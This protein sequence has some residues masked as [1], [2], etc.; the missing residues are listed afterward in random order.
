[1]DLGGNSHGEL[2][3]GGISSY[4]TSPTQV[5][6]ATNWEK[7]SAG[8]SHSLGLRQD[9]TLWAWGADFG[10]QIG[11][12]GISDLS[13]IQISPKQ[14]GNATD[15]VSS[16]GGGGAYACL[17]R[18]RLC[19]HSWCQYPHFRS[20]RWKRQYQFLLLHRHRNGR[21]H[22]S[23]CIQLSFRQP[24]PKYGPKHL[25]PYRC[26]NRPRPNSHRQPSASNPHQR[27]Q[28]G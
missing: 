27:L 28:S 14:V 21:R 24:R 18:R 10:G 2:G 17:T 6:T 23:T 22:R 13:T 8:S 11:D 19:L 7:I 9:G 25:H 3:N 26:W 15:W 20:N 4:E 12:G 16:V 1:M 5:G